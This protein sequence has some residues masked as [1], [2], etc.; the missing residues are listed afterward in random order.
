MLKEDLEEVYKKLPKM[1]P[2]VCEQACYSGKCNFE[3]CTVTGCSTKEKHLIN[4]TI[5]KENLNLPFVNNQ[6][7]PGYVLPNSLGVRNIQEAIGAT[8]KLVCSY[9][10]SKGCAIYEIRPLICRLFGACKEMPC[11][12]FKDLLIE[13]P[14]K[15]LVEVGYIDKE[16]L[17]KKGDRFKEMIK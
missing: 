5:L 9:L 7:D 3:C 13:F 12:H 11:I 10:T 14:F 15:K 6:Y 16:T 4:R 8:K 17:R 1:K 2:G